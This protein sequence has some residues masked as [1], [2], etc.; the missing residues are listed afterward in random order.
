MVGADCD[1]DAAEALRCPLK[2]GRST[3]NVFFYSPHPDGQRFLVNVLAEEGEATIN[4]ITHWQ[5]SISDRTL[6]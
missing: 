1:W 2:D 6:P 4:V 3:G 5:K